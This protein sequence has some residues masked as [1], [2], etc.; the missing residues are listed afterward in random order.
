LN[1]EAFADAQVSTISATVEEI[2]GFN[3]FMERYKRGLPILKE[4]IGVLK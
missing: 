4:A 2:E 3:V 1:S